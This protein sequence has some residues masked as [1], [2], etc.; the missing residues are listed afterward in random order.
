MWN[1]FS[2]LC[3]WGSYSNIETIF[4][5]R[6][7]YAQCFRCNSHYLKAERLLGLLYSLKYYFE[8]NKNYLLIMLKLCCIN[9]TE[10]FKFTCEISLRLILRC[11]SFF[12][13]G[14]YVLSTPKALIK[15]AI[16]RFRRPFDNYSARVM[17]TLILWID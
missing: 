14:R 10:S 12:I 17:A 11:F 5:L 4:F 9:G 2:Y 6:H 13:A 15:P 1:A 8:S 7:S 16:W 3:T